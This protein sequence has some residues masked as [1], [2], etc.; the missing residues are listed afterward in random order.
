MD[1]EQLKDI[2]WN[3]ASK[4]EG[5]DETLFRKDAAGA[6]MSYSEFCN[7]NSKFGWEIDY[8]YPLA[9]GGND[10]IA[11]LRAMQWENAV[12]KGNDYPIYISLVTAEGSVNINKETQ[13]QVNQTKQEEL[14][15]L[16]HID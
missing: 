13:R 16:Y 14:S 2:I 8:I 4:V 6:W 11:N 12:S 10:D 9:K 7:K 1:T 3:K 5:Y 15:R